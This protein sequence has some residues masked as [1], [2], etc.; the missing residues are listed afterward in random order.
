[1]KQSWESRMQRRQQGDVYWL[2]PNTYFRQSDEQ[3]RQ[4]EGS[5]ED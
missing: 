3:G 5:E 4:L 1:M 2:M